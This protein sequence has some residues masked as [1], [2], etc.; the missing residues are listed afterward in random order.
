M[1]KTVCLAFF[2]SFALCAAGLLGGCGQVTLFDPAGPIGNA[3]RFLIIATIVLMLIVVIPVY[4][5]GFWVSRKFRAGREGADYAPKWNYSAGIDS[6]IWL[7]PVAIVIVLASLAWHETRRLDPY[8]PIAAAERPVNIQVVS[9][10][11][12]WL[13][14]YPDHNIATV[15]ELVFP[16]KAPLSFSITSGTVM[17]SFFIP[18][19]GSQMYA[20]TGMETH[21]NLLADETGVYRC[22]NQQFSGRWFSDM[23]LGAVAAS[24]EEFED[25][26]RKVRGSPMKLDMARYEELGRPGAGYPVTRFSSVEPGLF[27]RIMGKYVP[28]MGGPGRHAGE[29]APEGH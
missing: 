2:G 16:V 27:H 7:V 20:M 13:F 9:L 8:K 6:V 28:G 19:L 15:N 12:K 29:N 21:L 22:Q 4:I 25:W 11:W 5:M 14:I 1:K 18:R 24:R 17:T 3:Q 10:D 23:S 26:V